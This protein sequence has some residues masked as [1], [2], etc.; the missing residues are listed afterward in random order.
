MITARLLDKLS[1]CRF[2]GPEWIPIPPFKLFKKKEIPRENPL[3]ATFTL[4]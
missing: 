3:Q 2:T 4:F 1:R